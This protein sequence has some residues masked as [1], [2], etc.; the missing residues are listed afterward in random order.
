MGSPFRGHPAARGQRQ[1]SRLHPVKG[2]A[3]SSTR[4]PAS[5]G[6]TAD[7]G[8]SA[9]DVGVPPYPVALHRERAEL[10][11]LS[12]RVV[13]LVRMERM[14]PNLKEYPNKRAFALLESGFRDGFRISCVSSAEVAV[15]H[16]LSAMLLC[17]EVVMDKIEG[18]P[19]P[20]I[21]WH[22]I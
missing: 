14:L 1:S 16:N 3:G 17:P 5:L 4:T 18:I 13:M 22:V 20:G 10:G 11:K 21:L 9:S 8:M 2:A 12:R 7:I 6:R 15:F 19:C